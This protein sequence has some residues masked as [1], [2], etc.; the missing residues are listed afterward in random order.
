MESLSVAQE[1]ENIINGPRRDAYGP[2]EESFKRHASVW[3]GILQHK[4][5]SPITPQEVAL[6]MIGLKLTREANAHQ[7]DNLTD[8]VGYTLLL[9]KLESG[10]EN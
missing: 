2:V 6:M 4:L 7:R 5:Q 10:S 1:A 8:I 9:E 3:T